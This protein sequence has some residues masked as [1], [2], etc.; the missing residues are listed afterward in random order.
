MKHLFL[1]LLVLALAQDCYAQVHVK[2]YDK[3]VNGKTVHVRSHL[4]GFPQTSGSGSDNRASA[5]RN[6]K[7]DLDRMIKKINTPAVNTGKLAFNRISGLS[8]PGVV[9]QPFNPVFAAGPRN[10]IYANKDELI[11]KIHADIARNKLADNHDQSRFK[12]S[13]IQQFNAGKLKPTGRCK[14]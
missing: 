6:D 5:S 11:A 4:R 3:T 7:I 9:K 2:A 8:G 14:K 13:N 1:I 10:G 12:L